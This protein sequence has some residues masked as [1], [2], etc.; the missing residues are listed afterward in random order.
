MHRQI[1]FQSW[2]QRRIHPLWRKVLCGH[3]S[4]AILLVA[5]TLF[6]APSNASQS[7]LDF[8]PDDTIAYWGTPE[9]L[10]AKPLIAAMLGNDGELIRELVKLLDLELN[11][12]TQADADNKLA[13]AADAYASFLDDPAA[14]A[15]T[16]GLNIEALDFAFY[17]GGLNPV[18]RVAVEDAGKMKARINQLD[19]QLELS[20]RII[21]RPDGELRLY[22]ERLDD[23]DSGTTIAISLNQDSIAVALSLTDEI[24][25]I[26]SLGL[27]NGQASLSQS[28]KLDALQ[29]RYHYS[30]QLLGYIDNRQ[31]ARA[32]TEGKNNT[33]LQLAEYLDNDEILDQLRTPVCHAELMELANTWPRLISGIT[34]LEEAQSRLTAESLSIVEI[35]H[36]GIT[37]SLTGIRGHVSPALRERN[38]IAAL[39]IGVDFD[40]IGPRL[41]NLATMLSQLEFDC[42][43]LQM[44]NDIPQETIQ[45]GILGLTMATGMLRGVRG[46]NAAFYDAEFLL[47]ENFDGD[48]DTM[49]IKSLD[50]VVALDA[51]DPYILLAMARMIPAIA[52][53]QF[54]NDGSSVEIGQKIADSLDVN[55]DFDINLA[56]Q[57]DGIISYAGDAG[58]RYASARSKTDNTTK[59][60][61]FYFS[62]DLERYYDRFF[63]LIK[64]MAEA[65]P[66]AANKVDLSVDEQIS[67]ISNLYP[68]ARYIYNLDFSDNG[69]EFLSGI[70]IKLD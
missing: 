31:I 63:D 6:A 4:G 23:T 32:F 50:T 36:T 24:A 69:I 30:G 20:P 16:I 25:L 46:V 48:L 51:Q 18:L 38:S 9:P 65:K 28:R 10:P 7:M 39:G 15:A 5:L 64:L 14:A 19:A 60:G 59:T 68:S 45:Q 3:F 42:A 29:T 40:Q 1:N 37:D 52:K 56:V 58:N 41:G 33:G 34:R 21:P 11:D 47:P 43:A 49:T 22:G 66:A 26:Q 13:V 53:F 17:F 12:S 44:A 61:I 55:L 8:V 27:G 62:L 57:N 67:I 35:N 2:F 54:P 70:D